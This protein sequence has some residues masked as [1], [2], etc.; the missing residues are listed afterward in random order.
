M[1]LYVQGIG[2]TVYRLLLRCLVV[3]ELWSLVFS[4][5]RVKLGM[6]RMVVDSPLINK[7]IIYLS[8][9]K[10]RAATFER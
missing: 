8:K 6:P 5:F 10:I 4:L 1:V 7:I 2:E 9:K 3:R